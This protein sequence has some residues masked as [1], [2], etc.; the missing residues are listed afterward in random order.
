MSLFLRIARGFFLPRFFIRFTRTR[1][2]MDNAGNCDRAFLYVSPN[3]RKYKSSV[4]DSEEQSL[5]DRVDTRVCVCV[6]LF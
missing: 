2:L 1:R 6:N 3:V 4:K 5:C